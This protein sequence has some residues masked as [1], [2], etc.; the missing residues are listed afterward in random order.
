M[1]G[2][3]SSILRHGPSSEAGAQRGF[4]SPRVHNANAR[5]AVACLITSHVKGD[6]W[7]VGLPWFWFASISEHLGC[8][9]IG[10]GPPPRH[11]AAY[12][13]RAKKRVSQSSCRRP[14]E[15]Q[16]QLTA[17]LRKGPSSK[18][19]TSRYFQFAFS[20]PRFEPAVDV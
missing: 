3:P 20:T 2:D 12:G 11:W 1:V 4:F 5:Q 19:F 6:P 16:I 9:T 13:A 14:G 8:D 10:G 17:R 7:E 18:S 15:L